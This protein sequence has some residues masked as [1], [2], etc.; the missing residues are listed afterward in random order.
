MKGAVIVWFRQDLRLKDNPAL[1]AAVQTGQPVIP[2]YIWSPE[3]EG[4]WPPGAA[5][6]WWLHHSLQALAADLE[7]HGSRLILAHGR[8]LD[9]LK[10]IAA[11]TGA[12]AVHWN[13]R[14]E[15]AAVKCSQQVVEGLKKAKV[16]P[17]EFNGGL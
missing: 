1:H 11:A 4:D 16:E 3:E 12:T 6:K 5:S 17:L 14:Y 10:K 7:S 13:K 8:A 9:V 2:V 15:P